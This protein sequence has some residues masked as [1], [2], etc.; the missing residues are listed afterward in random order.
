ME[1]F[2]Y[3][4]WLYPLFATIFGLM[5]G[6]FLN[7]VIYRTPLMME[8][9]WKQEFTE[10]YPELCPDAKIDTTPLSL[11]TPRSTCPKC[12]HQLSISDNIPVI[13]WLFLKGKCRYCETKISVRYPAV[14]ILTATLSLVIALSFP[15][16][17]YSV[18][19]LFFTFT[20]IAATFIDLD[21]LLLPDQLTLPLMWSGIAL[22]LV[23]ESPLSLQDSVIGAMAGYLCLWS[24]Y[25]VFKLLTGK[26]GMGYGDFK[27]LAALGAWLGWQSLPMIVLMSSLVGLVF[28]LIQ[29]RLQ[30][31][32]IE[33]VFP[34]GPYLA[35]AGW[36]TLLFGSEIANWYFTNILGI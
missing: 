5:I 33:H 6:S 3:Y 14:E 28:G 27:L 8:R 19:L 22:A 21:T 15:L 10:S 2:Y 23:G 26:D 34:F 32:G 13:S 9:E 25:K 35:I 16:S 20:L 30:R 24:V 36:L 12:Q 7:V 29:L 31:K 4:P 11:S 17:L 1:A 18:A